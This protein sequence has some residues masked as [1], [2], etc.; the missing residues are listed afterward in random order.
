MLGSNRSNI[1]IFIFV[2]TVTIRE[3]LR[4]KN[5]ETLDGCI[6]MWPLSAFD[7]ETEWVLA[8]WKFCCTP[9]TPCQFLRCSWGLPYALLQSQ[10]LYQPLETRCSI[11]WQQYRS[12]VY[13]RRTKE[14]IY[15]CIKNKFSYLSFIS[16]WEYRFRERWNLREKKRF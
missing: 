2:I 4:L 9:V 12:N 6:A 5:L 15:I 10:A 11:L 3:N 13:L 1:F 7:I 16:V 8:R 14:D